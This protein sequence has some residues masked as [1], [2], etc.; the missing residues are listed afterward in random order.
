MRVTRTRAGRW[1]AIST[2]G[3]IALSACTSATSPSPA[4]S[5][6]PGAS[7]AP[8]TAPSAAPRGGTITYITFAEPAHLNPRM[9]PEGIAFQVG[10]LVNRGLTEFDNK[11]NVYA[12]L[13][14]KVPDP[15]DGD[16]SADLLTVTWKIKEGA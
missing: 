8:S 3:V 4:A 15:A 16:V 10:E 11:G 9:L 1:L 2:A 7:T 14:E 12:E 6:P 5:T 13:A